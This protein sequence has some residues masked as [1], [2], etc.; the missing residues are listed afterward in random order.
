MVLRLIK[1]CTLGR[2]GQL[3]NLPI[4]RAADMIKNGLAYEFF[5]EMDR[6]T[7]VVEPEIKEQPKKRGRPKKC[8][9]Q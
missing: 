9:T 1:N 6:E 5:S 2:V 8:D 4:G 3:V 7:K